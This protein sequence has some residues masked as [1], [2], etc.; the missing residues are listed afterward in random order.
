MINSP[1]H[2][3]AK[4][5][6]EILQPVVNKYSTFTVKDTFDFCGKLQE[7]SDRCENIS[8][9]FMCSFD[10]QSLFTN[11]ALKETVQICLDVSY[12]DE[13]VST[14]VMTAD[15]LRKLLLK[16]TT[17]VEFS[18]D[19]TLYKQID[20]VAMGSPLGPAL[21]N[22]FVGY[23]ESKIPDHNLPLLYCRFVDDTF[24]IFWENKSAFDFFSLLNQMHKN[25][26][27][28]ME[29]ETG[30]GYPS[31]MCTLRKKGMSCIGQFTGKKPLLVC[32]RAGSHFALN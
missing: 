5:L 12:R 23:L 24:S 1:Q 30:V 13:E 3:L 16:A 29:T 11:V 27:F 17:D 21:A 9:T 14:L 10:I 4:W 20:R 26:Q 32:I 19:N 31:W 28:T 15:L 18:F 25:L 2:E 22:I 8:E 7:C 6:T